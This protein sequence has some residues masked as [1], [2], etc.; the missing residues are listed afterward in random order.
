MAE[1]KLLLKSSS[2]HSKLALIKEGHVD[3]EQ[4]EFYKE[5]LVHF[6]SVD[7]TELENA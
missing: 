4:A 5:K 1:V 6:D 2:E 3:P 7:I